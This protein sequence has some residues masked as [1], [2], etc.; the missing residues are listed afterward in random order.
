MHYRIEACVITIIDIMIMRIHRNVGNPNYN[1]NNSYL[2]NNK[3]AEDV[4]LASMM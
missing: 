2:N 4:K 1:I 3:I